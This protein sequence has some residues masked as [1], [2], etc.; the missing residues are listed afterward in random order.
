M[1]LENAIRARSKH[2]SSKRSGSP[3]GEYSEAEPF[4]EALDAADLFI[5]SGQG[6]LNDAFVEHSTGTLLAL[7]RAIRLGKRTVMLSQGI[8]PITNQ[9]LSS[10]AR[11]VLPRVDLIF[12][13]ESHSGPALLK[14][15]G[16]RPE[17][18]CVTGDDAIELALEVERKLS[19]PM[20][21]SVG[22]Q[23]MAPEPWD[24]TTR[25]PEPEFG[26][27]IG[28]NARLTSYS[29]VATDELQQLKLAIHDLGMEVKVP[30][31]GL[32]IWRPGSKGDRSAIRVLLSGYQ[33]EA[34]SGEAL[35]SP[36]KL[37][38]QVRRCSIVITGSYHAAVFALAL[39]VPVIA[40]S[41]SDYYDSKFNGLAK[42][43]GKGLILLR[44]R[45]SGFNS[46]V[47]AAARQLWEAA[48]AL[49][50]GLIRCALQ[51]VEAS[52]DAFARVPALFASRK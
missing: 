3:A 48:P 20:A 47:T 25:Y 26:H 5:V 14:S 33:L 42:Q 21:N 7:D 46:E 52:R 29:A 11:L 31:L 37:I 23:K 22:T 39:G 45:D 18:L 17:R 4:L 15:L 19:V 8:G 40:F 2:G 34:D 50:P 1:L 13:R 51:Q 6:S 35:D 27:G 49:K 38:G 12:V 24:S 32:P 41:N 28:I 43:F 9:R 16:C 36:E 30:L 44:I 10:L